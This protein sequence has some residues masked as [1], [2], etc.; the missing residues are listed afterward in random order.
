MSVPI[1]T[2]RLQTPAMHQVFPEFYGR[3]EGF[4]DTATPGIAMARSVLEQR[5]PGTAYV[6]HPHHPTGCVV[7]LDH[8]FI[9]AGRNVGQGFLDRVV[10]KI[11]EYQRA[12]LVWTDD[13]A[14]KLTPPSEYSKTISRLEF[15]DRDTSARLL[16]RPDS[17]G[18]RVCK[19][20]SDLLAKCQW[21]HEMKRVFGDLHRFF[22]HGLGF[23]LI[24]DETILAE[25]YAAFWGKGQVEIAVVT[26]QEH[27][28]AGH[29]LRVSAEL[30]EAC[31]SMGFET[32]WSC[33]R[34]NHASMMLARKLGYRT[35]V[36]YELVEYPALRN[37]RIPTH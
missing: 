16:G 29:G 32:Y 18:I 10:A 23:C 12:H 31:E 13:H 35:A 8:S 5:C 19:I 7:A 28:H 11:R 4:F 14:R 26:H 34:E 27:R 6:N 17:D 1:L 22:I 36:D 15:R 24:R 33:N 37:S 30:I 21:T 25:A 20:T 9:F 3:I 2:R